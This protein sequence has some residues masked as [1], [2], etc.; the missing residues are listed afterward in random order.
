MRMEELKFF[1]NMFYEDNKT[2]PDYTHVE[3]TQDDWDRLAA[4]HKPRCM[5]IDN[6]RTQ[7]RL[8][9]FW[10]SIDFCATVLTTIGYGN[11][12]PKTISGRLFTIVYSIF[13]IPLMAM[14]L[15]IFSKAI[16]RITS[17]ILKNILIRAN[18]ARYRTN[19]A[20]TGFLQLNEMRDRM[21]SNYR[22]RQAVTNIQFKAASL[23]FLLVTLALFVLVLAYISKRFMKYS[24]LSLSQV[25]HRTN[26]RDTMIAGVYFYIITLTSVGIG[27]IITSKQPI[28]TRYLGHV[29]SYQ[30]IRD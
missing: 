24:S 25:L 12:A 19:I 17:M 6:F 7:V 28:R 8:W 5:K 15:A 10:S 21:E 20:L 4:L 23:I 2:K 1:I 18:R 29:T 11:M 16:Y 26:G 22:A 3:L 9:N 30:P 14:Y 13:G 27:D